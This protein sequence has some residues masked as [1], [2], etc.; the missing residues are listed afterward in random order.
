MQVAIPTY[1]SGNVDISKII[2][3]GSKIEYREE[4]MGNFDVI[5]GHQIFPYS[6]CDPCRM[7]LGSAQEGGENRLKHEDHFFSSF[8]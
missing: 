2:K 3:P 6:G 5:S 1:P 4:P 8:K 7:A